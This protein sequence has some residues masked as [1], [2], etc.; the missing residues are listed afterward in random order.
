MR[1]SNK[2]LLQLRTV[3][4]IIIGW[5]IVGI[6]HELLNH[7]HIEAVEHSG[8]ENYEFFTNIVTNLI[9]IPFAAVIGGMFIV[10]TKDAFK[11]IPFKTRLLLEILSFALLVVV[12]TLIGSFIYN[13]IY[14][15]T[16]VLEEAVVRE[17]KQTLTSWGMFYNLIF[18]TTIGS[19]TIVLVQIIDFHGREKFYNTFTGKYYHPCLESRIF[20]FLDLRDSTR[21][22]ERLGHRQWFAFIN[23]FIR[24][25]SIAVVNQRGEIYQYVG[26]EIV[27]TWPSNLGFRRNACINFFFEAQDIIQSREEVYKERFGFVPT[28]RAS[29]HHGE[30]TAGE[31]GLFRKDIIYT[32]DVL[33]TAKRIQ[34]MCD[35]M[36]TNLLV[37]EETFKNLEDVR[38][39]SIIQRAELE[40]KGK[41]NRIFVL[42][43][44]RVHETNVVVMKTAAG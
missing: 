30:V 10:F 15:Q 23:H 2:R 17:V 1:L 5:T 33:N 42:D 38:A 19:L 43:V 24:D 29:L 6:G 16:F 22:A 28:F 12:F 9:I 32:G 4:Y 36:K 40:L 41:E 34:G 8:Y 21:L 11:E 26:D 13:A 31:V 37:S 25:L 3:F 18:W 7:V 20:I 14:F 39:F 35:G 44:R 27:V